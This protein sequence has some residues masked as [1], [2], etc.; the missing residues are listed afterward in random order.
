[1]RFSFS[2]QSFTG[3]ALRLGF[4]LLWATVP[5]LEAATLTQQIS[6]AEV[7]VGDTVTVTLQVQNSGIGNFRFP[8]VDGL[9]VVGNRVETR[10]TFNN[11]SFSSTNVQVFYLQPS[12]AGD[13]TIPG[14][15]L[16]T[17]DNQVLHVQPMK[18]HV[19]AGGANANPAPSV[20]ATPP[21]V[22]SSQGPVIMPPNNQ[23]TPDNSG[24]SADTNSKNIDVP[25]DSDGH[26]AKVFMIITPK[27]T[28]TY[29]GEAI[30]LRIE[31][32]IRLDVIAPQN[33]LPTIKGSDFLMNNLSVRPYQDEVTMNGGN[34]EYH[35]ETWVTAISA[36][37]SGDFPLQMERDTYWTKSSPDSG[38]DIFGNL[39]FHRTPLVHGSVSSNQLVF[40]THSLP[41][42]GRPTNF[43]GAI[44]QFK[45]TGN[46]TPATV[47]VG[48][49]VGLHF[50]VSGEGNFDYV[51]SPSLA[52]DPNWKT[53]IPKSKIEYQ[54][55]TRTHGV[56]TFDQDV[57]PQKN[58]N[59]PL[60]AASFSYFDPTTKQYVTMPIPLPAVN[61]TG[62]VPVASA[63]AAPSGDSNSTVATPALLQ[64]SELVPNRLGFGSLHQSLA[65]VYRKPWFWILQAVL[66][67]SLFAGFLFLFVRSRF[68]PDPTQPERTLREHSLHQQEDA[69]SEAVRR[70]DAQ[71]FFLAARNAVQLQLGAQW[72]MRPEA[73]TL[74]EVQDRN[75]ELAKTLE[76]LFT[77]ASEVIYSGQA[78]SDLNLAEWELHV[79]KNLLQPQPA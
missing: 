76:P 21:P 4:F 25:L 69:M 34:D 58:G 33:S 62:S 31:F 15:D 54:E 1:M 50:A 14:F 74:A 12:R 45:V 23:P 60:P 42:E 18:L 6:P 53:Y 27:T 44:G 37:K 10:A 22:V 9:E 16:H 75:P 66:I 67:L 17:S 64:S 71:T 39:F 70:N 55:E 78:S 49:P 63:A 65:P 38:N 61:V 11:G 77:Q 5:C 20:A 41:Q 48:E 19:L 47:G 29:V 51:K 28:D 68:A 40:H 30:P 8:Q 57:I 32:Y 35:R 59:L 36:P 2:L 46:A 52:T 72:H 3:H 79:R 26:P 43:S 24:N 73:I 56:K 13:F 7:N